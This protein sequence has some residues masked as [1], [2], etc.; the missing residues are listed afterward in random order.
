M[1]DSSKEWALQ[2]LLADS[3]AGFRDMKLD[4]E[5]WRC[6]EAWSPNSRLPLS[7]GNRLW[8]LCDGVAT[9][10]QLGRGR[11]CPGRILAFLDP[12]PGTRTLKQACA[13]VVVRKRK[14]M[15]QRRTNSGC[16]IA[17]RA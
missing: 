11:S 10:Q 9:K 3:S 4:L 8:G 13:L 14:R 7:G 17:A 1:Q 16:S 15:G 6:L 5:A 2:L 12:R